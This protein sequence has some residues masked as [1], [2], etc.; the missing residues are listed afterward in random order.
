MC[1]K[2]CFRSTRSGH[3]RVGR[4]YCV[5]VYALDGD[6]HKG[7]TVEMTLLVASRV[8]FTKY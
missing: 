8:S 5:P 3:R 1:R 2:P 7:L 6:L 4:D